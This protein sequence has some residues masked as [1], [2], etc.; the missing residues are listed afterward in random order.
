MK[1]YIITILRSN[2]IIIID[3]QLKANNIYGSVKYRHGVT[4][5]PNENDYLLV[6]DF[7]KW[8]YKIDE[9]INKLQNTLNKLINENDLSIKTTEL[10]SN[11]LL[12]TLKIIENCTSCKDEKIDGKDLDKCLAEL[13]KEEQEEEK[14][15]IINELNNELNE[16]DFRL[17]KWMLCEGCKEKKI[18]KFTDKC[19]N[20]EIARF[21]YQSR[22]NAKRY[23]VKYIQ[24]IPFDE[25]K[26]IEYL[27]KGD[28]SVVYKAT[29]IRYDCR[30]RD[31]VL[32]R[33]YNNSSDDDKIVDI[34]NEVK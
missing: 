4:K 32:K 27:A 23:N 12:E 3:F 29:W 17:N 33:I 2:V 26:N 10:L 22:L 11:E 14:E 25:F 18:E 31:V 30:Y 15:D 5:D 20:E 28:F 34:L 9:L 16:I 13:E 24:W 21:L 7:E 19:G 6:F 1:F 8:K